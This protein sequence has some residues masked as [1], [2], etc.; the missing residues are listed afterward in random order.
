M[1]NKREKTTTKQGIERIEVAS[2]IFLFTFF[3]FLGIVDFSFQEIAQFGS[4]IFLQFFVLTEPKKKTK[5]KS[6][7]FDS[8]HF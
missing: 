7:Q 3:L 1:R 2:E 4:E 8:P 6:C 5:T